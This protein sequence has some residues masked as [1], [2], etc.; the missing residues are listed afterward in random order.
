MNSLVFHLASSIVMSTFIKTGEMKEQ[1]TVYSLVLEK[2][3]HFITFQEEKWNYGQILASLFAYFQCI[4]GER[5][6]CVVV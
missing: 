3:K 4:L 5:N 2:K 1:L 6:K